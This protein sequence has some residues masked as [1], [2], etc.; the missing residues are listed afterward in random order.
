MS[1]ADEYRKFAE[2][3]RQKAEKAM[4]ELERQQWLKIAEGWRRLA[5]DVMPASDLRSEK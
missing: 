1:N 3:C 2:E 5:A 4:G